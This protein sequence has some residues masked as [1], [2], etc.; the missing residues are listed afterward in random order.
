[1]HLGR[2]V[3][4]ANDPRLRANASQDRSADRGQNAAPVRIG[5]LALKQMDELNDHQ[6]QHAKKVSNAKQ[7]AIVL[8]DSRE[9]K[10]QPV[11]PAQRDNRDQ[12]DRKIQIDLVEQ[13]E[14]I[15]RRERNAQSALPVQISQT[16]QMSQTVRMSQ[17]AQMSQTVQMPQTAQMFRIAA[18]DQLALRVHERSELLDLK[19]L[20]EA[21]EAI[22]HLEASDPNVRLPRAS[23]GQTA[24]CFLKDIPRCLIPLVKLEG[25]AQGFMTA[26]ALRL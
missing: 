2:R 6:D 22:D 25:L 3:A 15:D 10:G 1:M 11:P 24:M 20:L 7:A 12:R 5:L 17:T 9:P 21:K 8:K 14:M 23:S 13:F 16:V 19:D 26:T 18:G 4:E